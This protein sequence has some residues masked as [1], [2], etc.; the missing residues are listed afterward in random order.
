MRERTRMPVPSSQHQDFA[1]TPDETAVR[2]LYGRMM[3]GWNRGSAETFASP[4]TEDADFIAFDG[5]R[6]RGRREIEDSHR[7]LFEKWLKGTR[8]V[9]D[10]TSVRFV[11]PDVALMHAR[12]G[13]DHARARESFSGAGVDPDLGR[14]K[15][16]D[17]MAA[18]SVSQYSRPTHRPSRWWNPRL[19][20]HRLA[21]EAVS[22]EEV[23]S[24]AAMSH[25]RTERRLDEFGKLRQ[26]RRGFGTVPSRRR[27]PRRQSTSTLRT[28][29][30]ATDQNAS[31]I[32]HLR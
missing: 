12:G 17:D 30:P 32:D 28:L 29:S 2:S 31:P 10:V 6:L 25:T 8:L 5:T 3:E 11:A 24:G 19:V 22:T 1:R 26:S 4:F 18:G 15:T 14:D 7:A 9:G 21:L 23:S 16:W 20:H 13:N 27:S